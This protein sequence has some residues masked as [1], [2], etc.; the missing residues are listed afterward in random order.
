MKNLIFVVV[1]CALDGVEMPAPR[2]LAADLGQEPKK[3][4][5]AKLRISAD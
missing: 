2:N 1:M 5:D 4:N 3:P